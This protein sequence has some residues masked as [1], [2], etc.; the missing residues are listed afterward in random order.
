MELRR[1]LLLLT[2]L[3]SWTIGIAGGLT[4]LSLNLQLIIRIIA[5]GDN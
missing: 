2:N 1:M 5:R 3:V 4:G